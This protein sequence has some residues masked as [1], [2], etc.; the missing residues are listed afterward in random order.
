[1]FM[2]YRGGG[3]GHAYMRAIE[4]WLT[5]TG[6]GSDDIAVTNSSDDESEDDAEE[7]GDSG[8]ANGGNLEG[9]V[10][11]DETAS[12]TT[13]ISDQEDRQDVD[14]DEEYTGSEGEN[15]TETFEGTLGF[16]GF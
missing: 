5:E 13:P 6:W 7:P 3:V 9:E 12:N 16:S 4:P 1:M 2:R 15:E 11:D 8:G 10:S 14:L